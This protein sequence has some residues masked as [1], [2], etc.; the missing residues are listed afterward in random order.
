M[1]ALI[2]SGLTAA[3]VGHLIWQVYAWTGRD[4]DLSLAD[5]A[6][7]AGYV[8]LGAAVTLVTL[9][10]RGRAT[11]PHVDAIIDALTVVVVTVTV[12]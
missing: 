9:V 10:W 2:A 12:F 6:F 7:L 5:L 8:G 3:A 4:P 11:R 1:P